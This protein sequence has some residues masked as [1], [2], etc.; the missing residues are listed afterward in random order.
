MLS[1]RLWYFVKTGRLGAQGVAPR[2]TWQDERPRGGAQVNYP[3]V[4]VGSVFF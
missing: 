2:L 4:R 1:C 3:V